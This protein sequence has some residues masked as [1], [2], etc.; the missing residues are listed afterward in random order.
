MD[1]DIPARSFSSDVSSIGSQIEGDVNGILNNVADKLA[2]EL[3]I[4]QF[5]S[6]HLLDLCEGYYSPNASVA[7]PKK[8]VTQCSNATAMCKFLTPSEYQREKD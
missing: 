1:I 7:H 2:K 3:G 4:K 6:L 8:N 5:Y